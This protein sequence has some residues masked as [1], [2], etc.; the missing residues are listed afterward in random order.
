MIGFDTTIFM[1]IG[2][3]GIVIITGIIRVSTEI[4]VSIA[5]I[6]IIDLVMTVIMTG[7]ATEVGVMTNLL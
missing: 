6:I 4:M 7:I 1:T 3:A 5:G 2:G